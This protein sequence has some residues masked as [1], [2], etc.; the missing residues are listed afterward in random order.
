MT[1]T[2]AFES[3]SYRVNLW[4]GF[5]GTSVA[6]AKQTRSTG[7]PVYR[8]LSNEDKFTILVETW[9]RDSQFLSSTGDMAELDSYKQIIEMGSSAI[10]LIL[11][12][13]QREPDYLFTALQQ[14]S[15]T[16]PVTEA[17]LGRLQLMTDAWLRWGQRHGHI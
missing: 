16:N 11:R 6:P 4:G 13:L 10:P 15:G 1:D 3:S 14:I 5:T 8:H 12:E 17:E 9:K 7:E 2:L